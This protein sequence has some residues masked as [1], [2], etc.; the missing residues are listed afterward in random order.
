MSRSAAHDTRNAEFRTA[1]KSTA[2]A[3]AAS[4]PT[5]KVIPAQCEQLGIPDH[6]EEVPDGAGSYL[7]WIGDRSARNVVLYFHGN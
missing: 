4:V 2:E 6:I 7:H 5:R 1:F 3:K